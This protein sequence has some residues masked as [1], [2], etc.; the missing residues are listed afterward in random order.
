MVLIQSADPMKNGGVMLGGAVPGGSF[1]TLVSLNND[2]DT[3]SICV[4]PCTT[5]SLIDRVVWDASLG[6]GY[7]GHALV[8][9]D[10]ARRC[11]ATM[12][13]GDAG[14]FGTPGT[15]NSPCP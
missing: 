12:P 2:A 4:G 5:G 13:F 6:T 15:A 7:D 10:A 3:I 1:G 11:P 14:S 8:I 9:D